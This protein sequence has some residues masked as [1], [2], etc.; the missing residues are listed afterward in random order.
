MF[1]QK[2]FKYFIGQ[3]P[4][5]GQRQPLHGAT[6]GIMNPG[7]LFLQDPVDFPANLP[8]VVPGIHVVVHQFQA[9]AV[10]LPVGRI[11]EHRAVKAARGDVCG[12]I[13]RGQGAHFNAETPNLHAEGLRCD[14]EGR[15]AGAVYAPIGQPHKPGN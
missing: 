4:F 8:R 14:P 5:E 3:H 10:R 11:I 12:V 1:Q 15:L 13:P 7:M 2:S 6:H 9:V